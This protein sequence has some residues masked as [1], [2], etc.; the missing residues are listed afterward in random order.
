[1]LN[2]S[3]HPHI[4]SNLSTRKIM[5]LVI[6][7]LLPTSLFGIFNFTSLFGFKYGIRCILLIVITIASCVL[8]EFIFCKITKREI[9]IGDLS[10]VVTGLI[11]ALNL[12]CTLP[13]WMAA[14]GGVFA[15]VIVKMVFGGLG[16]NFMN[17]ALGARC[18]LVLSFAGYMTKFYPTDVSKI[19]AMS[20]A[21]PLTSIKA[22]GT[23][24]TSLFE[25]FIGHHSGT[26]GE[27]SI[28][29]LLI[30]ALI[31]VIFKVIDLRIP[32]TY[33]ISFAIFIMLF[34]KSTDFIYLLQQLCGGG[35]IFGAFFMATDY[36]TS[37]MSKSGRIIYGICLGLLTAI[38]RTFGASAEGVS[39][40]I[41]ICNL[42][43]PII[44]KFTVPRAFGIKRR[45]LKK[46]AK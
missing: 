43:V 46:E 11:L 44:E 36:T 23:T 30:G 24:D 29:A 34:N 39:F 21:T 1:M 33:I 27:T 37:P 42:L 13:Y 12:P 16:Q 3:S 15:I 41:I 5:A 38:L 18:F 2:V 35:L 4:K 26:I 10:A 45:K 32:L 8:S 19:D 40:A 25:M 9:T 6:L 14:L 28:L 31:L 17:P 20:S 22:T 7:S